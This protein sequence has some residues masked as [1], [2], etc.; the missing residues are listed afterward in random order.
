MKIFLSD[1]DLKKNTSISELVER[2]S[3]HPHKTYTLS[4]KC[5][6]SSALV[7]SGIPALQSVLCL[8]VSE[9]SAMMS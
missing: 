3:Q 1:E 9:L 8:T 7:L 2:T 5:F 4:G 6:V